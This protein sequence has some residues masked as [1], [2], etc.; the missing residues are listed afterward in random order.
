[1]PLFFFPDLSN[2]E[3][4]TGG[5]LPLH[6]TNQNQ[7]IFARKPERDPTADKGDAKILLARQ[8]ATLSAARPGQVTT[9]IQQSIPDVRNCIAAYCQAAGVAL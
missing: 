2:D 7:L 4:G 3:I 1:M 5:A 6:A 8:L 9:K